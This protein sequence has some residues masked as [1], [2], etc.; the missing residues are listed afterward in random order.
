MEHSV[1]YFKARRTQKVPNTIRR[2]WIYRNQTV[3]I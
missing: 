1:W 2:V 3:R